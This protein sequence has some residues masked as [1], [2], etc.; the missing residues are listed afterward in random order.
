MR[1]PTNPT[2]LIAAII[3]LAAC[4]AEPTAP[5]QSAPVGARFTLAPGQMATIR[6]TGL[7]L[8][9]V[10]VVSESRCPSNPHVQCIWEGTA[11]LQL[12]IDGAGSPKVVPIETQLGASTATVDGYMIRLLSL[13]PGPT[14]EAAIPPE[15]YRA[16]FEV[17]R[18]N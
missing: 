3:A 9:F 12:R 18:E 17:V 6:E 2:S 13:S 1:R 8:M 16:T 14:T 10:R 5:R 4:A 15:R 7:T 11:R